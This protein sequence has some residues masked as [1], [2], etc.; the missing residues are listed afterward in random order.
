[1]AGIMDSN[2]QYPFM[3]RTFNATDLDDVNTMGIY[4]VNN[5]SLSIANHPVAAQ[6]LGMLIVFVAAN[7]ANSLVQIFI[8]AANNGFYYRRKSANSGDWYSSWNKL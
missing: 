1:M 6:S 2:K 4:Y 5:Y 8:N 3:A 7:Y